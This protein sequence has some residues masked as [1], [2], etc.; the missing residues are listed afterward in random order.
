[1]AL[2]DK[3][4]IAKASHERMGLNNA[5]SLTA[6]LIVTFVKDDNWLLKSQQSQI[7]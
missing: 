1:L 3:C 5:E 4:G 7:I 2:V 6:F